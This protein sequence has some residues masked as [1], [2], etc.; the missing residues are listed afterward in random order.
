VH[1]CKKKLGSPDN[2]FQQLSA[3]AFC[4]HQHSQKTVFYRWLLWYGIAVGLQRD[5]INFMCENWLVSR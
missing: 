1:V 4:I 5:T 3:S 2:T